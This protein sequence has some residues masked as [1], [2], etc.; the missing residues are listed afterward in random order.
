MK[1]LQKDLWGGFRR[2]Q[3]KS[4]RT[5]WYCLLL[6]AGVSSHFNTIYNRSTGSRCLKMA[7]PSV[8]ELQLLSHGQK[9][10]ESGINKVKKTTDDS[11][12]LSHIDFSELSLCLK[13]LR[14]LTKAP[15]IS[16]IE[17]KGIQGNSGVSVVES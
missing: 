11:S 15:K 5:R 1:L 4:C 6:K 14:G 16:S 12:M 8:E 3:Q 17:S 10:K 7:A 2:E 13:H 9:M